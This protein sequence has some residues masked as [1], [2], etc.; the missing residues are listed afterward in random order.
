MWNIK[1]TSTEEYPSLY[2]SRKRKGFIYRNISV[3][4]RQTCGLFTKNLYYDDYPGSFEI[5]LTLNMK[6]LK[7]N[8][9]FV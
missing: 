1:A 6:S 8:G 5:P 3:L 4:P 2:P 7:K 9:S